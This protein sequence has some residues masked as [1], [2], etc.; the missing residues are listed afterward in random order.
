METTK[1]NLP[2]LNVQEFTNIMQSAPDTLA[3]NEHSVSACNSAGKALIDTIEANGGIDSEELDAEV[4]KYIEKV[5]ITIKN[6]NE[7]RKPI[8]QLL[9]AVSKR[10]TGLESEIDLKGD[11]I[12]ARMQSFR[13]EYAAKKLAEQKRREEEARRL[14]M[15]E[16]EKASYRSDLTLLL[17]GI[18]SE[19]SRCA[20]AKIQR[21]YDGATLENYDENLRSIQ[22]ESAEFN[23]SDFAA[24]VKDNIPLSYL[25]QEQR[26]EI[27]MSVVKTIRED[28]ARR[29]AD[30]LLDVR[31]SL[32]DRM[33]SKRKALE[34]EAELAKQNAELA[35][36]AEE[37]RKAREAEARAK[38][39][40]EAKAREEEARA[41]AEA[42]K[43][44]DQAMA[45]F[46]FMN[47]AT[48][49]APVNAKVKK[50]IQVV[51]PKGFVE[52]YQLW[53]MKEGCNLSIDELEKAHKKM[54]T[55][56]EKEANK[57]GG[58][59]INSA[60]I[61]YVDEVKAKAPRS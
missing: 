21:F 17:E 53:F 35:R 61:K 15:I 29:Y 25:T 39:E 20:V 3:R 50:V 48:P 6:M 58:E 2:V 51:H 56:C 45:S 1:A 9:Q 14:Q 33:P 31:Q 4:S 60:Y 59:Q 42:K 54:I 23:W 16:N 30:V 37:E 43:Q 24:S 55:F 40:A 18:F 19:Y 44:A 13:N 47:E 49:D 36:K 12:P 41:K 5:K 22:G 27:K 11:T 26:N 52:L 8:T 46:N 32:L 7:R 34:E 38:A 57:D 28:M 10:F